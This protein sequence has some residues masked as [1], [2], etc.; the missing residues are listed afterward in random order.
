[1]RKLVKVNQEDLKLLR[2][3]GVVNVDHLWLNRG[4][5]YLHQIATEKSGLIKKFID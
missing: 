3:M 2:E 5:V 4:P 1:M